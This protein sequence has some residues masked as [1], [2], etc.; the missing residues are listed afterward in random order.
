M[1]QRLWPGSR[2]FDRVKDDGRAEASLLA[3]WVALKEKANA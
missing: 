2:D 1:A 3:R